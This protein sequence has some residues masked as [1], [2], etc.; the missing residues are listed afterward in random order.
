MYKNTPTVVVVLIPS[1]DHV[2][3]IRRA[4]DAGAGKLALPGGYQMSGESWREAGAREVLEEVGIAVRITKLITV[5]TV[6]SGDSTINLLF[7][8]ADAIDP[9]IKLTPDASEVT[10]IVYTDHPIELA[11]PTHTEILKYYFDHCNS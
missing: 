9:T 1:G 7:C 6:G 4:K 3:L 10:G 11:F 2:I 8:L 5:E